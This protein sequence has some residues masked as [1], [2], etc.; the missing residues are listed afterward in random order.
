MATD[1]AAPAAKGAASADNET[2]NLVFSP[3]DGG[4]D[5]PLK[6]FEN[7]SAS[8]GDAGR[9]EAA[10]GAADSTTASF[11]TSVSAAGGGWGCSGRA[12]G[13]R[14][15]L[16]A[17]GERSSAAHTPPSV[18]EEDAAAAAVGARPPPRGFGPVRSSALA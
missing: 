6:G 8:R 17:L 18:A 13:F 15:L 3:A 1:S 2:P 9:R 14:K 11:A 10:P 7:G 4:K 5:Q 16:I 12:S